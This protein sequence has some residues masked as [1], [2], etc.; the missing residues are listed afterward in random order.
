MYYCCCSAYTAHTPTSPVAASCPH[1]KPP[2][3]P[4]TSRAQ[5][6]APPVCGLWAFHGLRQ[7]DRNETPQ[8]TKHPSLLLSSDRCGRL[9]SRCRKSFYQTTSPPPKACGRPSFSRNLL[10]ELGG[11]NMLSEPPTLRSSAPWPR[12]QS[13]ERPKY[14]RCPRFSYV[15]RFKSERGT[16]THTTLAISPSAPAA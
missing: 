4:G 16:T 5:L 7:R 6:S 8:N 10:R 11:K 13:G 3:H 9:A 12:Q 1:Q 15:K 14:L 2:H